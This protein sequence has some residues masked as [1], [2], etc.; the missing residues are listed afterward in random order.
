MKKVLWF[1][2]LLITCVCSVYALDTSSTSAEP[3]AV[4]PDFASWEF[5]LEYGD[6]ATPPSVITM[7]TPI[8]GTSCARDFDCDRLCGIWTHS[9]GR[10]EANNT[11]SCCTPPG[12]L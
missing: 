12:N 3:A 5:P 4:E 7:C 1:A 10:C 6:W 8:P 9:W 2:L 11:C